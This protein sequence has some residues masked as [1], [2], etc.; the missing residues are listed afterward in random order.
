MGGVEERRG[1]MEGCSRTFSCGGFPTKELC[2]FAVNAVSTTNRREG[3]LE[4]SGNFPKTYDTRVFHPP[5]PMI[6]MPTSAVDSSM[7]QLSSDVTGFTN[8]LASRDKRSRQFPRITGM[9]HTRV[10]SSSVFVVTGKTICDGSQGMDFSC[11]TC[12]LVRGYSWPTATHRLLES[13]AEGMGQRHRES[14]GGASGVRFARALESRCSATC[15]STRD[16]PQSSQ[17]GRSAGGGSNKVNRLQPALAVLGEDD[18]LERSALEVA[19]KK[20]RAQ[21]VVP[22]VSEQI[23]HIQK[24]I[25]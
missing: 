8:T 11:S 3:R 16:C 14:P 9:L 22:P 25:E 13:P 12:G 18:E 24:L 15:T 4:D 5:R 6:S 21:A 23:E 2:L 17:S 10:R 20:A 7:N 1:G 19:L